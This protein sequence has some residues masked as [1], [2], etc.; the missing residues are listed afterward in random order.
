MQQQKYR[1]PRRFRNLFL[2]GEGGPRQW[3]P[4]DGDASVMSPLKAT[5][6]AISRRPCTF[7]TRSTSY[8]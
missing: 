5:G 3:A 7:I 6:M 2:V 8:D 1:P 4:F